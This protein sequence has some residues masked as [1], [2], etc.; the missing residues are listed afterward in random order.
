MHLLNKEFGGTVVR[1]STREDGQ[2]TIEVDNFC[3]IF[4]RLCVKEQVLLTHGD[5]IDKVGD[6]FKVVATSSKLIAAIANDKLRLYGL[7]FHPEVDL[8]ENGKKI[9]E[10]FLFGISGLTESFTLEKRE[11]QCVKEIRETVGSNKVLMLVSGGVDSTVCANLLYEALPEEQ[12]IAVHIDN[13]FMRKNESVQVE[14]LLRKLGR[15]LRVINAKHQFYGGLTSI[16]T[17]SNEPAGRKHV[18]NLLC[19]TTSPEEKRK[20]IGDVFIQ[21]ANEVIAE[22]NLR[23][24]EVMLGQGTLRP[25]LIESASSLV[26]CNAQTIKTHHNDSDLVRV[27]R[28]QGRVVEPLKDFH[29]D[30]VCLFLFIN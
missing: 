22:L 20:I 17:N 18:T 14:Q 2:F 30:E 26:S 7:Q 11:Q 1:K 10:N 27:L 15:K 5:S 16:S 12:V 4:K 9:M 25:D 28:S 23:P 3:H 29:K 8:T 21:V 19:L 24:E 13:G 6:G